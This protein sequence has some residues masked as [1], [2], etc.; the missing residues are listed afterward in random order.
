MRLQRS[1]TAKGYTAPATFLE[2]VR[3]A[4]FTVGLL[5]AD[6]ILQSRRLLGF[7]AIEKNLKG[8]TQQAP[9]LELEHLQRRHAILREGDS[10]VGRL[11]AAVF[12]I[13]VYGRARWSDL[14]FVES[15]E[16]DRG[17]NGSMTIFTWEHKT[18]NMGA[19]K[20]QPSYHNTMGR[21]DK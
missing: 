21:S 9:G 11:G 14:R 1:S 8:P 17:R 6:D 18:S 16:F 4:K 15:L 13:C 7:A 20:E 19:R 2:T 3:F 10:P 5:G 12:L